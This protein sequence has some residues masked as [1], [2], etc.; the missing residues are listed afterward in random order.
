MSIDS[1]LIALAEV[2]AYVEDVRSAKG[3]AAPYVFTL[4][5]LIDFYTEQ[6]KWHHGLSTQV[7]TTRLKERLIEIFPD[8]IT[9]TQGRDVLLTFDDN[10]TCRKYFETS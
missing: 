2:V 1:V 6:I 4:H 3:D 10:V 7:N 9:V 5:K 8:L